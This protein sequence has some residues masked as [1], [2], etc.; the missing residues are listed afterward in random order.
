VDDA[1]SFD[2]AR[3]WM[4]GKCAAACPSGAMGGTAGCV[5]TVGGTFGNT[6]RFGVRTGPLFSTE[7]AIFRALD[8]VLAFFEK[9]AA[10]GERL[11]KT[12]ERVGIETLAAEFKTEFKAV[13]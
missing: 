1:L 8:L 5:M 13:C 10:Q 3:C 9:H 2:K 11:W 6:Q 7:E 12:L 4:C